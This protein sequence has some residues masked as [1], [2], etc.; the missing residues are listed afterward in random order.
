MFS[1]LLLVGS[2]FVLGSVRVRVAA[3]A[4]RQKRLLATCG[5]ASSSHAKLHLFYNLRVITNHQLM[6]GNLT[7]WILRSQ[8][9]L[10]LRGSVQWAAIP[11]ACGV[12]GG[13]GQTQRSWHTRGS[14]ASS[15]RQALLTGSECST[16]HPDGGN[17]NYGPC[18]HC[19]LHIARKRL[20]P[21]PTSAH[22]A[23]IAA[24]SATSARG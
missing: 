17:N 23:P 8:C 10:M 22:Q 18:G 9:I 7:D 3:F 24:Q 13:L 11:T 16:P 5:P 21:R 1:R 6:V 19:R 2:W 20:K 4:G 15:L 12:Q 14:G